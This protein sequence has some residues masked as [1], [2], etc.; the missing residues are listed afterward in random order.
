MY[1]TF[2]LDSNVTEKFIKQAGDEL[3]QAHLKLGLNFTLISVD[4]VG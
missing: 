1:K 3:G 2:I 4:M